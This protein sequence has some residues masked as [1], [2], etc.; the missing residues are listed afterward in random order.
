MVKPTRINV[1]AER[2]AHSTDLLIVQGTCES[3]HHYMPH[4][5][6]QFIMYQTENKTLACWENEMDPRS[7]L[8]IFDFL[9]YSGVNGW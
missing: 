1:S 5:F 3:K 7:H 2:Y 8:V 9:Y 4:E 6:L